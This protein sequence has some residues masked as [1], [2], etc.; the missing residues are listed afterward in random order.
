MEERCIDYKELRKILPLSRT[1]LI[2]MEKDPEYAH[3]GFPK[4]V[5]LGQC[6]VCWWLHEILEWL[7]GRPRR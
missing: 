2:R 3:L 7:K 6:R 1:H 4:R 5:L